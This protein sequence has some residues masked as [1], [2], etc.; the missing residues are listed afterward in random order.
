MKICIVGAGAVGGYVGSL[1]GFHHH[2]ITFIARGAHLEAIQTQGLKLVA[3]DGAAQTFRPTQATD[4]L[5]KAGSHDLVIVAV[6]G[7]HLPDLAP[8]LPSLCHSTTQILM[9]QNGIPWW[10]F[11]RFAGPLQGEFL[12]TTDPN[13]LIAK[14]INLDQVLGCVVYIAAGIL[15]PGVIRHGGYRR[16]IIGELDG[17]DSPRLQ[18]LHSTLTTAGVLTESTASIRTEIW[19]KLLGNIAINT[20]GALTRATQ[21]EV[22][23]YPPT[24]ELTF[25][26]MRE[27]QSI[28]H[29]L[30]ITFPFS[31]EE[32]MEKAARVGHHKTSMLQDVENGRPLE[33]DAILGSVVEM[34]QRLGIRTPHLDT[35]YAALQLL[36]TI[37]T[38]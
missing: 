12:Q 22:C 3:K 27:T 24:R 31:L 29:H 2:E 6:K 18:A 32:R 35:I 30:G 15:S 1:L 38:R 5:T 9:A 11:Y 7:H 25:T 28:A 17:S 36:N 34:G 37:I 16:Y 21:V 26:L 14:H 13:G 23:M 19:A 20:L 10:H 4:D 33:I 8:K